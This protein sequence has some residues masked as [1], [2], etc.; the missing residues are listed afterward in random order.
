MKNKIFLILLIL[1]IES[2]SKPELQN[3]QIKV[4][5]SYLNSEDLY[6]KKLMR[7]ELDKITKYFKNLFKYPNYSYLYKANNNNT[8]RILKCNGTD[9]E[10]KYDKESIDKKT[11]LLIFPRIIIDNNTKIKNNPVLIDCQKK[12]TNSLVLILDFYFNEERQMKRVIPLNF[13]NQKY[14]WTIIRY[15]LS[16]IGFNKESFSKLKLSNNIFI[17]NITSLKKQS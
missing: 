2:N 11:F 14:Q 12:G 17:N 16:S 13:K 5:F 4:D 8:D 10:L 9:I 15:I 7:I 3:F 1:I 6:I